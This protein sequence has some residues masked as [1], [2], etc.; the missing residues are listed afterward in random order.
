MW[1]GISVVIGLLGAG[2]GVYLVISRPVEETLLTT[3]IPGRKVVG[4]IRS[5]LH[6]DQRETRVKLY[7]GDAGNS[8][9]KTEEQLLRHSD[10][11]ASLGRRIVEAL[12]HGPTK[13]LVRTLP[14]RTV[15]NGFYLSNEGV[16]YVDLSE[17]VGEDHPGGVTT[18]YLTVFSIVNSLVLNV[19]EI[20]RVKILI[21]GREAVTL[22]GHVDLVAAHSADM[23]L[24]R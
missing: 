12:I 1:A 7:F 19:P 21:N 15:L 10:D 9:L 22:A 20:T 23:V 16:S 11:A 18:E 4:R 14:E 3:A 2:V 13:G 5:G 8:C 17:A 24:V 6:L